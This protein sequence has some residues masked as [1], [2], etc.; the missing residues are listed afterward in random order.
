[1]NET[2]DVR[3]EVFRHRLE[4]IKRIPMDAAR[5]ARAKSSSVL[6]AKWCK[7]FSIRLR[8]TGQ[9]RVQ[10]K[11]P[12]AMYALVVMILGFIACQN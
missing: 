6:S 1:M 3:C 8:R 4:Q 5:P 2:V 12:S 9:R 10:K 11:S 7:A